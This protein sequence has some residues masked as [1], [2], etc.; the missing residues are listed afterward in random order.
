MGC[1]FSVNSPSVVLSMVSP[2]CDLGYHL[3][4]CLRKYI[5]CYLDPKE[6]LTLLRVCKVV[7][8]CYF[9]Y[10]TELDPRLEP[11]TR[12]HFEPEGS[13]KMSESFVMY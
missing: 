12:V 2:Y 7:R 5:G 11:S 8:Y 10:E 6:I 4:Y 1:C 3:F 9:G 13:F